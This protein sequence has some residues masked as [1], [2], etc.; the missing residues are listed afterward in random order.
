M[1]IHIIYVY[2]IYH[3]HILTYI[4]THKEKDKANYGKVLTFGESEYRICGILCTI[5]A[6]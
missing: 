1:I 5:L 4:D 3:T 6:T 2:I